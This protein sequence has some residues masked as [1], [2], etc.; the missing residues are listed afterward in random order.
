LIA[1]AIAFGSLSAATQALASAPPIAP[2][3]PSNDADKDPCAI[4][5]EVE[6]NAAPHRIY[7][8]LLDSK[9][10]AEFS[11]YPATIG[12]GAGSTFSMFGGLIVGRNIELIPDQRIVQAWR[13]ADWDPGVYSIVKFELAADGAKTKLTLD[14]AG[15]PKGT[16]DHLNSGWPLRYWDPLKKYL[17]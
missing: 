8:V 3:Q 12:A 11:G 10:F 4:H 15:F 9:Q 16:F 7:E 2:E 6:L 5:Q 14:H 13:P 17:G 1:G